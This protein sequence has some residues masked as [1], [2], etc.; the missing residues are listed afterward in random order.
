MFGGL[1]A[2]ASDCFLV[3]VA[4][5]RVAVVVLEVF[6]DELLANIYDFVYGFIGQI[7]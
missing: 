5:A 7:Y 3:T 4:Y 6:D 2:V 1:D